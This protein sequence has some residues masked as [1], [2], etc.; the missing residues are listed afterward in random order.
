MLLWHHALRPS[1]AK[2]G[3]LVAAGAPSACL[4][5][6]EAPGAGAP[7]RVCAL[8][9]LLGVARAGE[10]GRMDVACARTAKVRLCKRH[11]LVARLGRVCSFRSHQSRRAPDTSGRQASMRGQ[12][13]R[14]SRSLHSTAALSHLTVARRKSGRQ[15]LQLVKTSSTGRASPPCD[16]P[17]KGQEAH[18]A[19]LWQKQASI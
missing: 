18:C 4:A 1:S 16:L 3:A 7:E 11:A 15:G 14:C 13:H 5:L 17:Q 6:L 19:P 9:I 12:L 10:A 2:L 8:G